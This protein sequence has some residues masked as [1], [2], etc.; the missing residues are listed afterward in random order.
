MT[1]SGVIGAVAAVAAIAVANRTQKAAQKNAVGWKMLRPAWP[2]DFLLLLSAGLAGLMT[3]LGLFV[4]SA[5]PDG[6][7]EMALALMLAIGSW[8]YCLYLGWTGHGRSVMWKGNELR[9]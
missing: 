4:E 9:V 8:S 7:T 5:R 2:T 1:V 3:W 6:E